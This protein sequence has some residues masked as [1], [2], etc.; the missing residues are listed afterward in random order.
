LI[1]I[2]VDLAQIGVSSSGGIG[3]LVK[4]DPL[5]FEGTG[6]SSGTTVRGGATGSVSGV[7]LFKSYP[8]IALDTLSSTGVT[9]GRLM[10]FKIKASDSGPVSIGVFK[11]TTTPTSATISNLQLFGFTD[12]S[13]SSPISGQGSGGQIGSTLNYGANPLNFTPTSPVV[14][15]AGTFYYFELRASV[16]GVI[17]GSSIVS[18]FLGDSAYGTTFTTGY[19]A[20]TLAQASTTDAGNFIWSGNST[21]T[22]VAGD[23]DW[24]NG[25][26]IPGLPSSGLIQ[27]R[28]N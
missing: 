2:K 8:I 1:T 26:S 12:S 27:T 4:V 14:I 18:K 13:Y 20:Q 15:P 16:A 10:R 3:N 19:N 25:Y 7:R 9:D 6:A 17:S 11:A 22:P 5:N 23:L 24:S 28:S 21:S